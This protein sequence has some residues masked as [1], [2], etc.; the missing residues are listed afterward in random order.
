MKIKRTRSVIKA[1]WVHIWNW[2][3]GH[4]KYFSFKELFLQW[5]LAFPSIPKVFQWFS[6]AF[7][8][9]ANIP[10]FG[11]RPKSIKMADKLEHDKPAGFSNEYKRDFPPPTPRS[12]IPFPKKP[13]FWDLKGTPAST[14]LTLIATGLTLSTLAL[15][16]LI[17]PYAMINTSWNFKRSKFDLEKENNTHLVWETPV[18][19]QAFK[20]LEK[21]KREDK[22]VRE[23]MREYILASEVHDTVIPSVQS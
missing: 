4:W 12:K 10:L 17:Y 19:D 1:K 8:S 9:P 22:T 18:G 21:A 14:K 11:N 23:V 6:S 3:S 7:S 5:V 20:V 2:Q 13:S 15:G 16:Y